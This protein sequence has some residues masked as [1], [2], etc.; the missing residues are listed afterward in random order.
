MILVRADE[1]QAS[2]FSLLEAL[3]SGLLKVEVGKSRGG[4]CTGE[5]EAQ[6]GYMGGRGTNGNGDGGRKE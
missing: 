3:P 4:K 6:V 1:P 5:G 2:H